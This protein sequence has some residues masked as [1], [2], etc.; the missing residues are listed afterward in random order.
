MAKLKH[1][2]TA[3]LPLGKLEILYIIYLEE[4]PGC[5]TFNVN[6]SI[7]SFTIIQSC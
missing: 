1:V 7:E 6:I 3:D 2:I 4:K 5:F